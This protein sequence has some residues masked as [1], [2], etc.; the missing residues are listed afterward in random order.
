[1]KKP[2]ENNLS[3]MELYKKN[4][5]KEITHSIPSTSAKPMAK[6]NVPITRL[7]SNKWASIDGNTKITMTMEVQI[8]GFFKMAE[9]LVV[10][11]FKR[12]MDSEHINLKD[13]MES[14]P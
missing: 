4:M 11:M 14:Q 1:M 9:P 8:G 5:V 6:S 7:E 12:Q 13:L 10:R 3:L 2:T